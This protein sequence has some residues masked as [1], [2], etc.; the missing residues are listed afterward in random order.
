MSEANTKDDDLTYSQSLRLDILMLQSKID[1]WW[2][3]LDSSRWWRF[4]K[5]HNIRSMIISY[6]TEV[7]RLQSAY[8]V[9]V[10]KEI[11]E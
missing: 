1:G 10:V 4:I 6:L 7:I 8:M 9:A 5:R 2:Y 3:E 11:Y